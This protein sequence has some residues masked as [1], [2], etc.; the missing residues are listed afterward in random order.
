L[1]A[2]FDYDQTLPLAIQETGVEDRMGVAVHDLS[3]LGSGDRRIRAYL[4]RPR[5][6]GPWAGLIF[7]HP[8]FGDRTNFLDESVE[9]ARAGALSLVVEA[10]WAQGQAW[11]ALLADPEV[12]Q[13]EFVGIA[14]D[15]RRGVDLVVAQP[16]VDARRVSYIGHSFGALFGGVLAG[17]ERRIRAY[18]LMAGV[19]SFTDVAVINMPGLEGEAL[20]TRRRFMDPIDPIHYVGHAAPAALFYQFGVRDNLFPREKFVQYYEAGSQ[21]KSMQWYDADHFQVNGAGRVDRI[22]WLS[23]QLALGA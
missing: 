18:V 22:A 12:T 6:N 19:G 5:R 3:Y 20:E 8:G 4:V 1:A 16:E 11:G 7:V 13:Q 17:V 10:P 21:P 15:L 14:Q 9:L 23:T 2:I